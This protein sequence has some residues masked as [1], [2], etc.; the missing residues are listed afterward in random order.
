MNLNH[1]EKF[2]SYIPEGFDI[3]T[4]KGFLICNLVLSGF[5]I[6]RY[7]LMVFPFYLLRISKSTLPH[8]RP[9]QI[10]ME[11][12]YSMISTI[13][14]SLSGYF[15]AVFWDL[16][17]S[18]IYLKFNDY[19]YGYLFLSFIIYALVHEF[20]FYFT[21]IWMHKPQVFKKIHHI[22]HLSNPTSPWASFSFH[23]YECVIHALFLPL[24]VLI[25]PIHPVVLISYLSFMTITAIINHLG[26]EILPFKTL[27]SH[28][29][30]STHHGFH[31]KY[32]KGNY[33]L[34]FCFM[35]R[36]MNTEIKPQNK[37]TLV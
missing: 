32:L 28:F 13:F 16:N 36:W 24:M 7:F 9:Q 30:S 4:F 1:F 10:R 11:I 12:M 18:K 22:H 37:G 27:N 2:T 8:F 17:L 23:P 15:T 25:V 19:S 26:Y 34:Y 33:G 35:D 6:F 5:I 31:H 3:L 14:F 20:Y 21:H 29:I